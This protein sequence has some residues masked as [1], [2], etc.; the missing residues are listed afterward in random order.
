MTWKRNIEGMK[1][2]AKRRAQETH[3]RVDQAITT[4]VREH[5][6]INFN[7]VATAAG[8]T[9]SYLYT[10]L[11][12]RKRIEVLRQQEQE[13]MI[14]QRGVLSGG[15]TNASRDL[16]ILAKDRRIKELEV[17]NR[18]LKKELQVALGKV[19]DKL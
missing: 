5:K 2:H 15:K 6:P 19:Y 3:E 12:F 16:V 18:Q 8:V 13:R 11:D 17:E 4:L 7:T 9:K 14:R 1:G 10:Q